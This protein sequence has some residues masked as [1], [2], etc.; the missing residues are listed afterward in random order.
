MR[1][2]YGFDE[3][4]ELYKDLGFEGIQFHGDDVVP[5]Y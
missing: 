5:I 2:S 1:E 4:V 3:K